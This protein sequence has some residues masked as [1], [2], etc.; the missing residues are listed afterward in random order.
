VSHIA[1]GRVAF[2]GHVTNIVDVLHAADALLMTSRTEGMP[3]AAIEAMLCGVPVV[4][5]PVGA[6]SSMHGITVVD[7]DESA[8]AQALD[9]V[10]PPEESPESAR[11]TY[12]WD[13]VMRTWIQLLQ[14]V[15]GTSSAGVA[16][17]RGR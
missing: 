3:G 10:T 17:S 5:T 12:S 4:A 1:P 7:P 13:T 11:A 14:T 9:A 2:L 16:P 15:A 8:L 6:T